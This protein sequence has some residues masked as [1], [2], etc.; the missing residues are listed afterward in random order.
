MSAR[1]A[2]AVSETPELSQ[3][4]AGGSVSAWKPLRSAVHV[5]QTP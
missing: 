1:C 3:G 4:S 2:K 5:S